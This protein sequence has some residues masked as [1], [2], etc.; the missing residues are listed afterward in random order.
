MIYKSIWIGRLPWLSVTLY[1][2]MGWVGLVAA[3][4]II[5]AM[6]WA[7]LGLM[8]GGGLLYTLGV[9]FFT[10]YKLPFHHVIWHFFVLAGAATQF[11]AVWFYVLPL[12]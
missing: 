12:E 11:A 5:M 4:P 9:V 2:V 3:W 8:L 1:I 10:W 6:P 7:G